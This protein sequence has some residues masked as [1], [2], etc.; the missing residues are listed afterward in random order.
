[1]E[2]EV[3]KRLRPL[4]LQATALAW[5]ASPRVVMTLVARPFAEGLLLQAAGSSP[6]AEDKP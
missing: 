1:M 4:A 3:R 5:Y 6:A 2:A